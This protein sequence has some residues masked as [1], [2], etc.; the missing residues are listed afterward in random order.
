MVQGRISPRFYGFKQVIAPTR[1]SGV[2]P[3]LIVISVEKYLQQDLVW[4]F[5]GVDGR[6][7]PPPP[8]TVK[9]EKMEC[10]YMIAFLSTR[11]LAN[12]RSLVKAVFSSVMHSSY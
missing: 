7:V 4:T 3:L 1:A 8:E 6:L 11:G 2:F 12:S 5:R 10:W 9:D